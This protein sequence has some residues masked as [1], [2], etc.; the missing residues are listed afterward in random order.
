MKAPPALSEL[1]NATS[2]VASAPAGGALGNN[3]AAASIAAEPARANLRVII[4]PPP[5]ISGRVACRRAEANG[6]E[7]GC[8]QPGR[9]APTRGIRDRPRRAPGRMWSCLLL[10]FQGRL[11]ES[12]QNVL[13]GDDGIV[14][15]VGDVV[16]GE[17]GVHGLEF[18][19]QRSFHF[20]ELIHS[21]SVVAHRGLYGSVGTV[22]AANVEVAL[23]PFL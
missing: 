10:K 15:E 20:T 19:Q 16:G 23:D 3:A 13:V 8:R 12:G 17:F 6:E 5:G 1:R 2:E 21:H 11:L 7:A 22:T 18:V 14:V 9:S 4:R